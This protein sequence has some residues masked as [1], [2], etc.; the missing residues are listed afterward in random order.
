MEEKG[1]G[2]GRGRNLQEWCKEIISFVKEETTEIK[3]I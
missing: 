2:R 1:V 3:L